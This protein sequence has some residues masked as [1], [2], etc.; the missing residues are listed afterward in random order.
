MQFYDKPSLGYSIILFSYHLNNEI[1]DYY[2][3]NQQY[4]IKGNKISLTIY[5]HRTNGFHSHLF[6]DYK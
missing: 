4:F 3:S 2:I 5:H 1:H 6:G